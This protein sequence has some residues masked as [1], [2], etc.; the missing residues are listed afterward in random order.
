MSPLTEKLTDLKFTTINDDEK[1]NISESLDDLSLDKIV[2]VL[3]ETTQKRN[4]GSQNV[5]KK[6]D[7]LITETNYLHNCQQIN[8][9]IGL[10]QA[11]HL[12]MAQST[13]GLERVQ[14]PPPPSSNSCF[15]VENM[16]EDVNAVDDGPREL[17]DIFRL[18]RQK[19][20]KRRK[21]SSQ[22]S[23]AV[24]EKATQTSL[25]SNNTTTNTTKSVNLSESLLFSNQTN[26]PRT[27]R[28][29]TFL[30]PIHDSDNKFRSS[31]GTLDLNL[32]VDDGYLIVHGQFYF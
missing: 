10:I 28:C 1:E 8:P 32:K 13:N 24:N 20:I 15:T 22:I 17:S 14:P 23:L 26:K 16:Q 18:T 7:Q 2:D 12:S 11:N 30:S 6:H 9:K 19:C 31:A 4:F 5:S 3:L 27:R 21:N 29:L 25:L